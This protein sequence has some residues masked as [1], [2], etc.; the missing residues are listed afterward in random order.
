MTRL[1]FKLKDE[2][3]ANTSV[4]KDMDGIVTVMKSG[5]QYQVVIGNH[6]SDVYKAVLS[7]GGFDTQSSADEESEEKQGLFNKFIDIVSGIFA[8]I[9]GVL[10]ASG[11]I[12]GFNALFV[13]LGLYANTTG[14]YHILQAV[15][16]ALFH[17]FSCIF[18]LYSNEK[19]LVETI[20]LGWL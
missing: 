7:V 8:P 17:F 16:D 12:K 14:T 5:G 10:A 18:G 11:M 3:K 9:L 15:G 19:N 6:V 4:L 20:S 1:R 2:D 13:A